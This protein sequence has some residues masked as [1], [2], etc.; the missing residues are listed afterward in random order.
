M[1]IKA[2]P[3]LLTTAEEVTSLASELV[4]H[5]MIALDTEFL[6][7]STFFPVVALIQIA[8]DEESWLVDPLA[9]SPEA[10]KPL[11]DVFENP[12]I[13]KVL[14]AAQADQECLYTSY[15]FVAKPS[16][17]TACAA[18]LCGYGD[19]IGLAKLL[20]EGLGVQLQ[21]G[22]ART[23]WTIR[24]IQEQLLRYAH[25]DVQ[26]LLPL[27]RKLLEH[28]EKHDRRGWALEL[29]ARLENK[30]LYEPNPEGLAHK[31]SK[32]GK[33]DRR[34][35]AT[36]IE[37]IRWREQRVRS[38]DVPRRRVA[39]D[40]VLVA[41]ANVRPKDM[42]HLS[43][44]RGL[45]SGELKRSGEAIL[46][47]IRTAA[48]IPEK[49][50]PIVPTAELPEPHEARVIEL[51]QCFVKLLSDELEISPR[52][53]ITGDDILPMLRKKLA[54]VEA[55]VAA[56]VMTAG[57]AKLIGEELLAIMSGK[58]GLSVKNGRVCVSSVGA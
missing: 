29:S 44:F 25:L 18:S 7:E 57:A 2:H 21:K 43:A 26:Y 16:L 10:L 45:N 40:D 30:K 54:T 49:D 13:L 41:L 42:Q 4:K 31:L 9:L 34:G 5:D 19:N 50:L 36:L 17:D 48:Q 8:T 1:R 20:K 3:K 55:L 46:A 52:H 23:D 51:V 56:D 12:K 53:L 24:P 33:L 35:L 27:A 58:R 32:S 47:A 22:H 38:L 37:L 39:D 28:L 14:H 6:R 11:L 15:G